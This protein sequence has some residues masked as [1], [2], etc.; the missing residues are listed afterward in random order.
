MA[1]DYVERELASYGYD[2]SVQEFPFDGTRYRNASIAMGSDAIA[3][4][5]VGG[6][7][8][9]S[10]SGV[11]VASGIGRPGEFPPGG[12]QGA[13]AFIERGTLTFAEKAQNAT[14]AGAGAIVIYN[15]EDGLFFGDATEVAVPMLAISREDGEQIKQRLAAG[16]V[17]ATARVDAP[18]SRAY[19]VVA[20]PQGVT[21]C[22][23][24]I[25]G[26]YDSVPAVEG[27]DDNATGTAGVFELARVV[28]AR[29]LPG[30]YCFVAFGAE[31]FGLY[32]S[33]S[34][35]DGLTDAE[36]N[37]VRAMLN[38][39][40]IGTSSALTLIGSED[41]IELARIE[42]QQVGIDALRGEVPTGASSDHASFERA[43]VPVVFFYRDDRL[44]HTT[45]DAIGRFLPQSLEETITVAYGVLEALNGG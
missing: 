28:A 41:M 45:A 30:S 8:S 2:V 9:G 6:S 26:H 1:R 17:Q 38:L 19:N 34:F 27:A 10:A 12:L 18:G 36:L 32:G 22:E 4:V 20:K 39:D 23:V 43:G 29:G 3:G 31:E 21:A 40:V 42:A 44:I 7:G 35:V 15:N 25:G 16:E 11:I 13:I 37:G 33:Q 5:A 24:V 14:A